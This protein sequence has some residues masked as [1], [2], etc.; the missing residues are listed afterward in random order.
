MKSEQRKTML[1]L[2]ASKQETEMIRQ[3]MAELGIVSMSAYLRKMAIDGYIIQLDMTEIRELTRLLSICSNNLNQYVKRA[4]ETGRIYAAD[5][6]DLS[7]RLI[8]IKNQV[9]KL[10][11]QFANMT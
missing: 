1:H 3:R 4:N 6:E 9:G 10:L 7:E 5:I 2:Y 8:V 11:G